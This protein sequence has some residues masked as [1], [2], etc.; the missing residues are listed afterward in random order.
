MFSAAVFRLLAARRR[1]IHQHSYRWT[2]SVWQI[3]SHG[4][5]RKPTGAISLGSLQLSGYRQASIE[6]RKYLVHRLVA[7]AFFGAP[8]DHSRW[9]VNH[10]DGDP[11]NNH[12]DNLQYVSN[13]ENQLHAW[14]RNESRT[15]TGKAVLWRPLGE[16]SWNYCASRREA[17]R[18]LGVTDKAVSSCC[19]GL[20]TKVCGH[21]IWY[22]FKLAE[23]KAC[24]SSSE[25]EVW[26]V[27]KY[28]CEPNAIPNL[29]VSNHGRVSPVRQRTSGP[30]T[31][32]SAEQRLLR[33]IK[34]RPVCCSFIAWLQEHFW[35][36]RIRRRCR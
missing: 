28:P 26:S 23:E 31:W 30:H 8:P 13:S 21:G 2:S 3:S 25:S 7:A 11:T 19:R 16:T 1:I 14:A 33:D 9:Q 20:T 27:A 35:M 18:L 4:R 24:L 17:Q 5:I 6:N 29:L 32:I 22:E 12:V 15:R 10:L 34:E 36:S